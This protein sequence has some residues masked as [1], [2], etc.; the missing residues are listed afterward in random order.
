MALR[1]GEDRWPFDEMEVGECRVL[2]NEKLFDACRSAI[3][4][5]KKRKWNKNEDFITKIV[6][7]GKYSRKLR[8]W[9]IK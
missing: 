4:K 3:H 1:P 5:F 2:K 9:R 6:P 7:D 8:I